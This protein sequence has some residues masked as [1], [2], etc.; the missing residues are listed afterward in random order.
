MRT[1]IL[2][3]NG[4]IGKHL[5]HFLAAHGWDVHS[6]GHRNEPGLPGLRYTPL[7]V[8]EASA[9]KKLDTDVDLVFYLPGITGTIKGYDDYDNYIDVNEKGLLHLLDRLRRNRQHH[10]RVVYPSSRLVYKGQKNL[11]LTEDAEK[12]FK[13]IYALNKW[14]GECALR[15]YAEYFDIP[16]TIFRICVP[17]ANLFEGAYGYGTVGFFLNKASSGNPIS[18]YGT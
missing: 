4:Y 11:P 14:F 8:R 16:F 9:F 13:T 10:T 3:A 15:Q 5:A 2:G 1:A 17:Y 18:L 7:D 6:Y 12:E